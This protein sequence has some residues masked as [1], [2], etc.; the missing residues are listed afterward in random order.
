[1]VL[2]L[3]YLDNYEL[4]AVAEVLAGMDTERGGWF[5]LHRFGGTRDG[6]WKTVRIP[7]PAD[8]IWQD[9]GDKTIRFRLKS[10]SGQLTI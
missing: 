3:E 8:L 9:S 2:E 1:V 4:P 7:A 6:N 5:E 10:G